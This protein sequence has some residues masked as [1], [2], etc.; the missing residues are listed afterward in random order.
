MGVDYFAYIPANFWPGMRY[1]LRTGIG[2]VWLNFLPE[3]A[4]SI[5]G[6][7]QLAVH[8]IAGKEKKSK[9]EKYIA[10]MLHINLVCLK[11]NIIYNVKK[12]DSLKN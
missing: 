8:P 4:Q 6:P 7:N 2:D 3:S 11:S 1:Q 9:K 12:K 5:F 10:A